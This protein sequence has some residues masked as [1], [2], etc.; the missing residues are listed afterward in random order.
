MNTYFKS[1]GKLYRIEVYTDDVRTARQ[2]SASTAAAEKLKPQT[3][4][5]A[6][7]PGGKTTDLRLRRFG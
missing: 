5:L 6:V 2:Q 7:L 1:G 4:I 3:P